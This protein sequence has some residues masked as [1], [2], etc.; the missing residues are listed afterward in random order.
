M[1]NMQGLPLPKAILRQTKAIHRK[2]IFEGRGKPNPFLRSGLEWREKSLWEN[3]RGSWSREASHPDCQV[4][5]GAPATGRQSTFSLSRFPAQIHAKIDTQIHVQIQIWKH[6][7]ICKYKYKFEI[8]LS[9][10]SLV[11]H[12]E[13]TLPVIRWVFT[14][15]LIR[16]SLRSQPLTFSSLLLPS[17]WNDYRAITGIFND[18][19]QEVS[20]VD[21][22]QAKPKYMWKQI[23]RQIQLCTTVCELEY[24]NPTCRQ[25]RSGRKPGWLER[26]EQNL[27]MP[28]LLLLCLQCNQTQQ[29]VH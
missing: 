27:R 16:S 25:S 21:P 10:V 11:Y 15:S 6:T 2:S 5:P 19:G 4:A 7:Y 3:C 28:R 24:T 8:W 20:L 1:D 18:Q 9:F 13:G 26:D 14:F 29:S 22:R 17:F 23:Q 12:Q